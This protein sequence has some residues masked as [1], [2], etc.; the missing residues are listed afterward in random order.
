[1][2]YYYYY[3][4]GTYSGGQK[5]KLMVA[6]A[7]WTRPHV[8]CLD[9]P[10]N[11]LDFGTVASLTRALRGFRGGAVVC[12]HNEDFLAEVCDEIWS[13]EGHEVTIVRAD[14]APPPP[15]DIII[16]IMIIKLILSNMYY[17][18]YCYYYYH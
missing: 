14:A 11:F 12:S 6:A 2:Y 8:V 7:F 5:S 16:I 4:I 1:M 18:Y 9:E 13:V 15:E 3:I 10:T 17:C